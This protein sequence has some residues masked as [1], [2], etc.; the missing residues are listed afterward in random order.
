M[1]LR[2]W[3][4]ILAVPLLFRSAGAL[5]IDASLDGFNTAETRVFE[6][7]FNYWE[8]AIADPFTLSVT[9]TK[10]SLS[11]QLAIS[12][13][14]IEDSNGLPLSGSV[15]I[16]DQPSTQFGW[17]VDPTPERNDEYVSGPDPYHFSRGLALAG[18][19][20]DL[21]TVVHHE[22]V[23]VLGFS[24][25]YSRFASNVVDSDFGLRTYQGMTVNATLTRVSDGTHLVAGEFPPDFADLMMASQSRGQRFL[26]S[27]LDLLIL[28]DAFGYQINTP[29]TVIPE[30]MT[31]ALA[32]VSLAFLALRKKLSE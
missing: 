13:N 14:F 9:F 16:D 10:A 20:Y 19:N 12:R 32:G 25:A 23:H 1:S 7:V 28:S 11:G 24:T 4:W 29:G 2:L 21:L 30:P 17:Y 3:T 6:A 22:L 27:A 18:Q 15:Q 26:P 8:Q 31:F 5:T